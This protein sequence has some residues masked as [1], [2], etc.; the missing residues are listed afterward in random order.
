MPY[1]LS[2]DCQ[3]PT[4]RHKQTIGEEISAVVGQSLDSQGVWD[5]SAPDLTTQKEIWPDV[6]PSIKKYQS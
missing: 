4:V 5:L 6:S 1:D 3:S 2:S